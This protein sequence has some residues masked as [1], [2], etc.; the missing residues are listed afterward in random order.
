VL[1]L[2]LLIAVG[3]SEG[4]ENVEEGEHQYAARRGR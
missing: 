2:L 3:Y 1:L 4:L